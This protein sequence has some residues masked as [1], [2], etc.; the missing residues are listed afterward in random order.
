[1]ELFCHSITAFSRIFE[2]FS[3]FKFRDI[4]SQKTIVAM[5]LIEYS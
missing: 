5:L 1:M 3:I 2:D 4:K